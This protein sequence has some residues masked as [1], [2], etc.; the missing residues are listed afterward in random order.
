MAQLDFIVASDL[1]ENCALEHYDGVVSLPTRNLLPSRSGLYLVISGHEVVYI[2]KSKNIRNR[3]RGST[4]HKLDEVKS[5]LFPQIIWIEMSI[6]E[7]NTKEV[8]LIKRF[9]PR[10]NR[11]H[12]EPGGEVF[13][14]QNADVEYLDMADGLRY[15]V[16][17]DSGDADSEEFEGYIDFINTGIG[18]GSVLAVLPVGSIFG[19]G[20]V[21]ALLLFAAMCVTTGKSLYRLAS[22]KLRVDDMQ[23]FGFMV[24]VWLLVP[25]IGYVVLAGG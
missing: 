10:L 21:L 6:D 12:W 1:G 9:S 8:E 5:L 7:A 4:H 23:S 11:V 17:N 3:W 19:F 13:I 18:V 24:F 15:F 2:G 22:E 25:V 20:S 14:G 16:E